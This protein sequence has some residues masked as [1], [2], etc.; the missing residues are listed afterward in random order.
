[1]PNPSILGETLPPLPI[2]SLHDDIPKEKELT[3]ID[4]Q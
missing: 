4:L 3:A 1:M 2:S